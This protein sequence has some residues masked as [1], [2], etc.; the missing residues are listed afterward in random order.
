MDNATGYL[1]YMTALANAGE[2]CKREACSGWI[3]TEVDTWIP[4]SCGRNRGRHPE[5]ELEEEYEED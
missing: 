2:L 5:D 1:A 3:P 4:C